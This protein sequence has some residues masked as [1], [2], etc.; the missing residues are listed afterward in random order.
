MRIKTYKLRAR[1]T[2]FSQVEGKTID[3]TPWIKTLSVKKDLIAS[4]GT[5]NISMLPNADKTS[6]LSWYYRVSP[7]DYVEIRFTR[8][9]TSRS[10]PI[11]MRGFVDNISRTAMVDQDGKPQ[12]GYSINGR[13]FGKI[14]EITRIY[15]LREISKDVQLMYLPGHERF[16]EKYGTPLTGKP[17]EIIESIFSVAR[18]QLELI[19]TGQPDVP[20]MDYLA[21]QTIE[22]AV[23]QFSLTQ[24]DGSIWEMMQ[25]FD[26]TPWNELFLID[27]E[28]GPTLVFRETP[29]KDFDTDSYVQSMDEEIRKQTV[30]PMV[31]IEPS[32]VLSFSLTRSDAELKNYFFTYLSL[33]NTFRAK[34][35]TLKGIEDSKSPP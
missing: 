20:R 10:I 16:K 21:S 26:N 17:A 31:N 35:L 4:A 7:M 25:F 9:S 33:S 1:I 6:R 28:T 14:L 13:D 5:F 8:D 27:L 2:L 22:G 24:D 23:N 29:W 18:N 3:L 15:Y 19:R 12:R 30:E 32:S 34:F 11:V